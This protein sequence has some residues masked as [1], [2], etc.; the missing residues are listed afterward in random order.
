MGAG[1]DLVSKGKVMDDNYGINELGVTAML[2]QYFSLKEM[3]IHSWDAVDIRIDFER[4][5]S[6]TILTGEDRLA[7]ALVYGMQ[8]NHREAGKLM[9]IK[10]TAIK[11]HIEN[12]LETVEAVLNG[13][14]TTFHKQQPSQATNLE[15]WIEGV[16]EGSTMPYDI[17]SKVTTALL[18]YLEGNR[19]KLAKETLRQRVEGNEDIK[20]N[21]NIMGKDEYDV[22]NYPFHQTSAMIEDPS[23]KRDYNGGKSDG[24]DYFHDQDRQNGVAYDDFAGVSKALKPMGKKAVKG[25]SSDDAIA[26]NQSTKSWVY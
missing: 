24:P 8:L 12:V 14:R 21:F 5:V 23:R 10:P 25:G 7:V 6:A 22:E 13:Y 1:K 11:E 19:D 18:T 3:E 2:D 20:D 15:E 16:R 26:G 4:A 17:P 9:G